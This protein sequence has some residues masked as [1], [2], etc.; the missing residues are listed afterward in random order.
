M[1]FGLLPFPVAGALCLAVR[2][3]RAAS[4]AFAVCGVLPTIRKGEAYEA[5]VARPCFPSNKGKTY[6]TRTQ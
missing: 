4:T 3:C 1:D 6:Q 5:W 2:M